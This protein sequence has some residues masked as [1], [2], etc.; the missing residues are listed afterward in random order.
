[1]LSTA[2]L[3]YSTS[4]NA[5]VLPASP[6]S[7]RCAAVQ[8]TRSTAV[9]AIDSATLQAVFAYDSEVEARKASLRAQIAQF[10]GESVEEVAVSSVAAATRAS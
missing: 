3:L 9:V 7:M 1:M 6:A 8:S 4:V 2:M 10:T 5:L